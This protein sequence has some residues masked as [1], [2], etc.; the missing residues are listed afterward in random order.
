MPMSV[1]PVI[2]A[3]FT[4]TV[5]VLVSTSMPSLLPP[6]IVGS[7][8]VTVPALPVTIY[9]VVVLAG[10]IQARQSDVRRRTGVLRG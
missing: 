2:V 4:V 6:L 10:D 8:T 9:A 1:L 3:L 7:V 5:P